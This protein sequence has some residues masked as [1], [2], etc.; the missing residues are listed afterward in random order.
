MG[1]DYVVTYMSQMGGWGLLD[2]AFYYATNATD[3]LQLGMA[4]YL[5][6]WSTMNTGTPESNYG[7]WYPGA[8]FDGGCGGGFEPAPLRNTWLG[9][10]PMHRGAWYYAAEQDVGF[11]G[12]MRQAASA[13]ADD[14]I[15]RLP[16]HLPRYDDHA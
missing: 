9:G 15:F 1:N 4:S 12:A 7:F 11:A 5:N 8:A 13:L 14:P 10:Q 16:L 3:Y 2:Y 6:G